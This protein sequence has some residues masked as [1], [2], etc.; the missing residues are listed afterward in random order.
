[1]EAHMLYVHALTPIHVGVGQ[2]AG[3]IDLPVIREKVTGW[4]YLPGSGV[5][6][7][8]RDA[9]EDAKVPDATRKIVFG[10]ETRDNPSEHAGGVIFADLRLLCLPVRSYKGGFAWVTSPLALSRWAR[11]C[12][13]AGGAIPA[14]AGTIGDKAIVLPSAD[15]RNIIGTGHDVRLE[16]LKLTSTVNSTAQTVA[17]AIAAAS[18]EQDSWRTF[19]HTHFGIV[20][21]TTFSFLTRT[22]TEIT[23][24]NRI[25]PDRKIVAEGA[26]WWEEAVP[27]ETIF[28]GLLLSTPQ[29][30]TRMNGAGGG[31]ALAR[32]VEK[33]LARPIQIGGNASVGRGL[34][35]ARLDLPAANAGGGA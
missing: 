16:D 27:A 35:N 18:F 31:G 23:A 10:P 34:A 22:A 20:S 25:D 21:D 28:A 5:K 15:A 24:R 2:G 6:G 26:L 7:V 11:D 8:L 30:I 13:M 4:P 33:G 29:G 3:I 14:D 12:A 19:F 1:M 32:E 9:C 17:E